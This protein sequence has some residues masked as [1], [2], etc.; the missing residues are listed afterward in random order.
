MICEVFPGKHQLKR[1]I[2]VSSG[3][4][5]QA[6]LN[7]ESQRWGL[8]SR[9][10]S[11]IMSVQSFSLSEAAISARRC[12]S[13]MACSALVLQPVPVLRRPRHHSLLLLSLLLTQPFCSALSEAH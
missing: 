11:S 2:S 4:F 3:T 10:S 1:T 12:E 9:A 5:S 8:T 7:E 13:A 6:F